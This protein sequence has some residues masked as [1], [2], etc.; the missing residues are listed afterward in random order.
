MPSMEVSN[1]CPAWRFRP[2]SNKQK[3][4]AGKGPEKRMLIY[5]VGS[6]YVYENKENCDKMPDEMP[7]IFG[8]LKPILQKIADLKGQFGHL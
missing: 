3:V 4:H 6:R 1:L 7:D 2:I 5:D 8:K